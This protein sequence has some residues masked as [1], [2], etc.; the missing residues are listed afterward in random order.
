MKVDGAWVGYGLG[1]TAPEVTLIQHRLIHDYPKNSRAVTLGVTESGTYDQATELAIANIQPFFNLPS[2]GIANYATQKALGALT[3]VTPPPPAHPATW[4]YSSPGSGADWNVGPSFEVGVYAE[5]TYGV[6]HQPVSFQ[7]GGY[8][9]LLGGDSTFSYNDVIYDQYQSL[10]FLLNNNR[11]VQATL[12]LISGGMTP[13][14]AIAQTKLQLIFSGYS[15]SADGLEDSLEILFGD[16]GFTI[17]KTGEVVPEGPFRTIRG[18]IRRIIQFGN[19]S[20]QQSAPQSGV[21]GWNPDGWGISRKVRP[22]WMRPLVVSITNPSDFYAAVPADE[23]IRPLFYGEIVEANIS[24]PFFVHV[25]NIAVPIIAED[26]P[27]VGGLLGPL[28][29]LAIAAITGLDAFLPLLTGL[30]GQMSAS[31]D[32][33]DKTIDAQITQLL[34]VQGVLSQIPELITMVGDLPGL[35]NHGMYDSPFAELGGLSGEQVGQREIDLI[36]GT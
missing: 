35:Q 29:P 7:K 11:D 13:A 24:A 28:A 14:A 17:P 4:F 32:A 23:K 16:G 27:I 25:L 21:V 31:G 36:F 10:L 33:Y 22:D 6:T 20:R 15:Q 19:P 8:L 18:A 30:M 2:T 9:G 3:L 12:A 34:S 1:D 5:N 26:I